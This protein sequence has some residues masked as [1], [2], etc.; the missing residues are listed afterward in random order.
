M[1]CFVV[2][3]LIGLLV[4]T[5][6]ILK[7]QRS[8]ES[9]ELIPLLSWSLWSAIWAF[10]SFYYLIITPNSLAGGLPLINLVLCIAI[11]GYAMVGY[12]FPVIPEQKVKPEIEHKK[13]YEKVEIANLGH[14]IPEV[15]ERAWPCKKGEKIEHMHGFILAPF[16]G[17]AII[18]NKTDGNIPRFVTIKQYQAIRNQKI[19]PVSR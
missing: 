17:I 2:A 5:L 8:P 1:Y 13:G 19:K 11:A 4:H 6:Q 7:Y 3:S 15:I 18:S 14:K 16:D 10:G 12:F 9:R